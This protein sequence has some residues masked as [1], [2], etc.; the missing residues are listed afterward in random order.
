MIVQTLDIK[1]NCT[2]LFADGQFWFEDINN[3]ASTSNVAW[4]HSPILEDERFTYIY[5]IAKTE[6]LSTYSTDPELFLSYR[7]KLRAHRKAAISAKVSLVDTCFFDLIPQ[8]QL[9]KWFEIKESCIKSVY[10]TIPRPPDYSILHK[11]HV[12]TTNISFQ[13]LI[14]DDKKKRVKYNI[15]GSVTGRLTTTKDSVPVL[16][17]KK[18]QRELLKPTNDAFVELDLNAAEVR[19]L[20]ALSGKEQPTTDIHDH[21]NSKI[22]KNLISRAQFK[23]RLFAWF[24]N[25]NSEDKVFNGFFDREAFASF[26]NFEDQQ[27]VT[28]FGRRLTVEQRKAQN[29]LLQSTTSDQVLE[30]VYMIQKIL[31]GTKS[32]VAFTLHD[33]VVLDMAKEDAFLLADIKKQFESTRWGNFKSTCKIGAN[34]GNLK[35]LKI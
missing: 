6:D 26:Y 9:K 11:A 8:H 18:E 2:G 15:F 31:L 13:D 27:L 34:F 32:K 7:E 5:P 33:S 35:E 12:L 19:M 24:Y 4:K 30:N 25:P 23:E 16:T 17:L 14:F 3:V 22:F 1:D 10:T 29:Y 21:L 28:P 20:M